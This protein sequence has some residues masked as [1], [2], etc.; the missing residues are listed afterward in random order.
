MTKISQLTSI[1]TGLAADDEFIIRDVSDASTPNKKVTASGFFAVASALGLTGVDIIT[2]GNVATGTQVRA[3]ASGIAGRADTTISG[4]TVARTTISG[5][6]EN[7]SGVVGG[8]LFPVV[9]QYDIG[10]DPNQVP[11]N[12]YLGTMAF[13]DSAGVNLD[14]ATIGTATIGTATIG[15]ATV[16]T[17]TVTNADTTIFGV[18]VGRG[19]GAISSNTAVGASALAANITGVNNT[20]IGNN[21]LRV[22][23]ANLNT[24]VGDSALYSC[25]TG[26][27]NIAVGPYA[28]YS[29]V[30]GTSNIAIGWDALYSNT[31]TG[32]IAIGV[33]A[34]R[35]TTSGANN[36]GI[37]DSV[38]L[39]NTTGTLNTVIGGRNTA[40]DNTTGS[41]NVVL[42]D[43]ALR[44]NTT[45]SNNTCIGTNAGFL[46]TTGS[47]N[48]IIGNV[49]GTAGLSDTV[50]IGAGST[51]KLRVS[52]GG[53]LSGPSSFAFPASQVASSD[54][55]TLDDYEE[56]TWTPSVGGTATYNAQTGTYTKIGNVVTVSGRLNINL[57]LTGSN[58]TV[59]G[60][61]FTSGGTHF[62]GIAIGKYMN[63]SSSA[64]TVYGNLNPIQSIFELFCTTAAGTTNY[65]AGVF[66]NST[67]IIF[68]FTY[69]I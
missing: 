9:T 60:L 28:L 45:G 24:A 42:G 66:G 12:G 59:S 31:A 6:Y 23:T 11:L 13:Q 36:I 68:S 62:Y 64:F 69:R 49:Q 55:N 14:Q 34:L 16:G 15:T 26:G 21:A 22:N 25:T 38:L 50:I 20:A 35:A 44:Y 7:A 37:G 65:L 40:Y 32:N 17:L 1:G 61:P 58:T 54:P 3:Y 33:Y 51:E 29:N 30:S 67:D 46:L 18:R 56:G 19:G 5:Y 63:I 2:A 57:I 52:S 43:L 4:I 10:T 48:T 47:N 27:I 53:V 8:T 39:N 41:S